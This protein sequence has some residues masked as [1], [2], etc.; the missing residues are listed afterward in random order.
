M[1]SVGWGGGREGGGLADSAG[2][3]GQS[4]FF[5]FSSSQSLCS[6]APIHWQPFLGVSVVCFNEKRVQLIET[7]VEFCFTDFCFSTQSV[8]TYIQ[9]IHIIFTY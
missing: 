2:V 5:A 1:F 3:A 6:T 8:L 4:K 9:G 7:F